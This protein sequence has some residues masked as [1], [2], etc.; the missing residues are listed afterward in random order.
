MVTFAL[1]WALAG[2]RVLPANHD[3]EDERDWDLPEEGLTRLDERQRIARELHDS[4][5]QLLV[6]L[7]LQ[8]SQ[9]NQVANPGA[10]PL[11]EDCRRTIGEIHEQIRALS[12]R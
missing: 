9:L 11:I 6:V 7:Q 3:S 4:T 5:S 12:S 1:V 2:G 8:L 10:A